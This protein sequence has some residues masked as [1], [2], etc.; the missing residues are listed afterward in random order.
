MVFIYVDPRSTSTPTPTPPTPPP[1]TTP[2]TPTPFLQANGT[3]TSVLEDVCRSYT[4]T[5]GL[6]F[7]KSSFLKSYPPGCYHKIGDKVYFSTN[8][9]AKGPCTVERQCVCANGKLKRIN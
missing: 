3:C 8:S 9:M 6:S 1:P 2:T 5:K 4:T 7:Q